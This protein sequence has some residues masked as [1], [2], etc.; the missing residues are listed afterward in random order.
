MLEALSGDGPEFSLAM[1]RRGEDGRAVII[2]EIDDAV[3]LIER[4]AKKLVG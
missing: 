3:A 2:G 4:A 1:I